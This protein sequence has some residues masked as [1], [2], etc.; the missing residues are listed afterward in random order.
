MAATAPAPVRALCWQAAR[1]EAAAWLDAAARWLAECPGKPRG[2]DWVRDAT[3]YSV[4]LLDSFAAAE[5]TGAACATVAK[6]VRDF[7]RALHSV[8][9]S[10]T[11]AAGAVACLSIVLKALDQNYNATQ[12]RG[13]LCEIY[14][15]S[16]ICEEAPPD[17]PQERANRT[18]AR[19]ELK[20]MEWR[21]LGAVRW[22]VDS[23]SPTPFMY[24]D[25]LRDDPQLRVFLLALALHAELADVAQ[26]AA[27]GMDAEQQDYIFGAVDDLVMGALSFER[28]RESGPCVAAAAAITCVSAVMAA[29]RA[30]ARS[31][32]VAAEDRVWVLLGLSAAEQRAVRALRRTMTILHTSW[33]EER[34]AVARG[35]QQFE[36]D[37]QH[38]MHDDEA[39]L[40]P[41]EAPGVAATVGGDSSNSS[42]PQ[43]GS[44]PMHTGF[45]DKASIVVDDRVSTADVAHS[46]QQQHQQQA[47]VAGSIS[48]TPAEAQ[49]QALM[50][51]DAPQPAEGGVKPA[52]DPEAARH[53]QSQQCRIAQQAQ[54]L[55]TT[56]SYAPMPLHLRAGGRGPNGPSP[57]SPETPS[58][59]AGAAEMLP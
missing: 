31:I 37:N 49:Q 4:Q 2:E 47:A 5:A 46:L 43:V 42:G 50:E 9:A 52:M 38:A 18:Y 59:L 26:W 55:A 14:L 33:V 39:L 11:L 13:A 27:T 36:G 3:W 8:P 15:A 44:V 22:E 30:A 6:E 12:P 35:S 48:R 1:G 17:S 45:A 7:A 57:W 41:A 28:A 16:L 23:R 53:V 40:P 34:R 24:A 32:E 21:V 19:R 25:T 51:I 20:A 54:H 29:G 56:S 10:T 58:L